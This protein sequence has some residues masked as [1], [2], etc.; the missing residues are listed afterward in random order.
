MVLNWLF[1]G[2]HEICMG[3]EC[4]VDPAVLREE[5]FRVWFR[6]WSAFLECT[7]THPYI[8]KISY[9]PV[10]KH[11]N[12]ISLANGG[13][14]IA[15]RIIYGGCPLATFDCRRVYINEDIW[16]DLMGYLTNKMMWVCLKIWDTTKWFWL[17]AMNIY[18]QQAKI[19]MFTRGF[20][21]SPKYPTFFV[22]WMVSKNAEWSI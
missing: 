8:M 22:T 5:V 18:E 10:R 2:F 4:P 19:L 3:Y 21:T 12:G 1:M 11:G 6:G 15:G 17:R 9:P 14:F 13:L 20:D 16:W 7:W